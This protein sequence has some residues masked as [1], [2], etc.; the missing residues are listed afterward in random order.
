V[1]PKARIVSILKRALGRAPGLRHAFGRLGLLGRRDSL[2]RFIAGR[3]ISGSGI[4]IGALHRPLAVDPQARVT[5]VDRFSS[6]ELRSRYPEL[7]ARD[8]VAVDVVDDGERLMTIRNESQDFVIANHFLEHCRSPITALE[9]M[10]RVLKRGGVLYLSVPDKRYSFDSERPVTSFDHI[11]K[12]FNYGPEWSERMHFEEYAR[13]VDKITD[14]TK[15]WEKMHA[16]YSIHFH[17]WSPKE[18]MELLVETGKMLEFDVEIFAVLKEE[19][20]MVLRKT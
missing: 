12:D 9:N 10:L 18:L 15:L 20:L 7:I 8:L 13:L 19:V 3:Y 14:Q 4:E 16:D 6:A 1:N 2:S 17:V 11:L 5:Y